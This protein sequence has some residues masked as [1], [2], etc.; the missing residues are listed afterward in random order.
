MQR[1]SFLLALTGLGLTSS[2][3]HAQVIDETVNGA[4]SVPGAVLGAPLDALGAPLGMLDPA[5]SPFRQ[6]ELAGGRYAIATSQIALERS[7]NPA[8]RQF[9]QL[10]IA[11]QTAIAAALDTTPGQVPMTPAQSAKVAQLQAASSR[12]FD[13]MYLRDQIMGHNQLLALNSSY[14]RTGDDLRDRTVA[15]LAV[16]TIQTHLDI[17]HRLS[18]G[19]ASIG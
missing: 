14:I 1:R 11:E 4:L 6:T 7:E 12:S 8:I 18:R 5:V 16:P 2:L 15:T 13:R 3:A 10:E 19:S 9:A 17:L